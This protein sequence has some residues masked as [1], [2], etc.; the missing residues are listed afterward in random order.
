RNILI[1]GFSDQ[2]ILPASDQHDSVLCALVTDIDFDGAPEILLGTYGQELLCYK[3]VPGEFR[4]LW[5]RRFPSPLLSMLYADLTADG[6]REL[7][8][9]CLK[10]LH[11]LQ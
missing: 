3:H 2:L 4:L 10:G 6:L 11:V 5:T 7:A 1:N 9:V 8:V